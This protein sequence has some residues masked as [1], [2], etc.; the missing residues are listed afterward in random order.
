ML[1]LLRVSASTG[2]A[3]SSLNCAHAYQNK[4]FITVYPQVTHPYYMGES[5]LFIVG[6]K[7]EALYNRKESACDK[8]HTGVTVFCVSVLRLRGKR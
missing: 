6:P 2:W 1:Y 4:N 3:S 8:Y 7:R 5:H